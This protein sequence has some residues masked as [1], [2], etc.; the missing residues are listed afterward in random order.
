[1]PRPRNNPDDPKWIEIDRKRGIAQQPRIGFMNSS[2][3]DNAPYAVPNEPTTGNLSEEPAIDDTTPQQPSVAPRRKKYKKRMVASAPAINPLTSEP[4]PALVQT[5][6]MIIDVV[7]D[8]GVRYLDFTEPGDKWK[9]AMSE[10]SARWI[11]TLESS[12]WFKNHPIESQLLLM[13]A[14]W[15]VPNVAI[16]TYKRYEQWSENKRLATERF[17]AS[18]RPKPDRFSGIDKVEFLHGSGLKSD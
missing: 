2:E 4:D 17:Q 13:T 7:A 3:P 8:T 14:Q 18:Q 16:K 15:V 10:L 6:S 1:M 11:G 5:C 9:F 12:E